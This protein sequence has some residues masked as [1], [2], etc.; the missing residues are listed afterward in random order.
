[1]LFNFFFD[2]YV[3]HMLTKVISRRSYVIFST[4]YFSIVTESGD[5]RT[6]G[7]LLIFY[8]IIF[9]DSLLN[10]KEFRLDTFWDFDGVYAPSPNS[11]YGKCPL[12][13]RIP[14]DNLGISVSIVSKICFFS[15]FLFISYSSLLFCASCSNANSNF[16][17]ICSTSVMTASYSLLLCSSSSSLFFFLVSIVVVSCSCLLFSLAST[18]NLFYSSNLFLHSSSTCLALYSYCIMPFF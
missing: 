9:P 2:A 7:N 12:V 11:P 6:T 13:K 1:M 10:L 8:F 4:T 17:F 3:K 16:L 14:K 18:F 15:S 5:T